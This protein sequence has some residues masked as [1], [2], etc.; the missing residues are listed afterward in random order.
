[1]VRL[2]NATNIPLL[3]QL[4]FCKLTNGSAALP[5]SGPHN[6]KTNTK[7]QPEET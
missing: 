2:R 5:P 7:K 4:A 6:D 1:M 3:T